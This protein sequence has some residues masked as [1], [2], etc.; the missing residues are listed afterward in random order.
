MEFKSFIKKQLEIADI[1]SEY[2]EK[3]TDDDGMKLFLTAVTHPSVE[4]E[5]NYQELEFIGD[6]IIKGI[7]SQ[8][9]PRRF[10]DLTKG[11][12]KSTGEGVLS[13]TRRFLEQRKT[14]SDFALNL[15]FWDYVRADQD[16]KERLR[17]ETLEDVFE[18]FIGALVEVIDTHVEVGLGYFYA[19][20]YVKASLDN[21]EI[22]I[23]SETLDDPIT[24]LNELYKSNQLENNAPLLKWNDASYVETRMTIPVLKTEPTDANIGDIYALQG[25]HAPKILTN[26]GWVHIS[27]APLMNIQPYPKDLPPVEEGIRPTDR[28][29]IWYAGAYG[30]PKLLGKGPDQNLAGVKP[31]E[32]LKNPDKYGAEI[33]GQGLAFT[34]KDAKKGAALQAIKYLNN[35]GYKK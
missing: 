7:L 32:I 17:K 26:H 1:N 11:S 15:G 23:S 9:I 28:Q 25:D 6:G 31:R 19:Y 16:T 3:F 24:R 18:A 5:N 4:P 2:R 34:K 10:P 21:L 35:L 20:K 33:I 27:Q 30:F 8:Y 14:L 22:I 13:K 12:K 29:G